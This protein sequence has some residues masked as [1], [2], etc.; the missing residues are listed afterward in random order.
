MAAI[1]L[2]IASVY[3]ATHVYLG[4]RGAVLAWAVLAAG[5]VMVRGLRWMAHRMPVRAAVVR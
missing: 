1:T 5:L 2:A 4:A 3:L